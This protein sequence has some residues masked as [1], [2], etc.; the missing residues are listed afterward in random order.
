MAKFIFIS[1]VHHNTGLFAMTEM[2]EV[3]Y[4]FLTRQPHFYEKSFSTASAARL[5]AAKAPLIDGVSR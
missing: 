1:S 5:P 3:F 4:V 2:T